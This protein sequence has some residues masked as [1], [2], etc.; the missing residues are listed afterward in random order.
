[1][2]MFSIH[3]YGYIQIVFSTRGLSNE[4]T[5]A[6]ILLYANMPTSFGS[7]CNPIAHQPDGRWFPIKVWY[8]FYIQLY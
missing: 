1:M 4:D 7:I 6:A 3:R 5:H 8:V 2:C